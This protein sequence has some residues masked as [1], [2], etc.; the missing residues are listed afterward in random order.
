MNEKEN[1]RKGSNLGPLGCKGDYIHYISFYPLKIIYK[2]F[3]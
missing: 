2:I 1:L 3:I